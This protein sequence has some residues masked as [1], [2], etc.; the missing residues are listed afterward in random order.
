MTER[1]AASITLHGSCGAR[2]GLAVLLLGRSGAGKSDLLLRLVD[3]GFDL[4]ADDRVVVEGGE[5][6]PPEA[7]AGL[8]E[9]RG[10]GVLRMAHVAPVKLGLAILLDEPAVRL[11][12]PERHPL[13]VPL[14]R[15]DPFAWS[16]AY[17]VEIALDCLAGSRAL[18]A[19]AFDND[20]PRID[21]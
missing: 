2:R 20:R 18:A 21:P 13:G 8:I 5:A 10:L 9:I 12:Q 17:R 3:R 19:G 4:V 11:P 14:L 6:A 1:Q 15:M 7:L 16:A